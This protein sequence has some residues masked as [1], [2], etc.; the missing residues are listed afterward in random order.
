MLGWFSPSCPLGTREK[1]WV[2]RRMAWLAGRF[3][4]ERL[5]KA[6]ILLPTEEFFPDRYDADEASAQVY[7]DRMCGYMG[8][9]PST[10]ELIVVADDDMPGAAG[11]YQM[12]ER[13]EIYVARSQLT[14]P[15]ELLSTYAHELAH[16][17]LLK[18]GHLTADES[19]HEFVTDILPV[20]LGAG[21]FL[22]NAT[23]KSKAWSEGTMH[24]FSISKQGYLSSITQG[25][26]LALFAFMRG[27][28]RPSWQSHLRADAAGP[29]KSGLRY[30]SKT[31]DTLFHPDTIQSSQQSS[32]S[33]LA[34]RLAHRSPTFRLAALW[35]IAEM[36]DP[37]VDLLPGVERCLKDRDADVRVGALESLSAFGSAATSLVPELAERSFAGTPAERATAIRTLG[38]IKGRPEIAVPAL[39]N[40]LHDEYEEAVAAAAY[41]LAKFGPDAEAAE[42]HLLRA[43]QRE[44]AVSNVP[45]VEALAVALRAVC[46]DLPTLLRMTFAGKDPEG[47]RLVLSVVR[48]QKA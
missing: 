7:F 18:G 3:G 36:S 13:S 26:A 1:T 32:P 35:D 28:I 14:A 20:F 46:T 24:L 16:E 25:Y 38:E 2:E 27:E 33:E 15:M 23:V 43:V 10:V 39:A 44:A 5:R 17:L 4:I 6:R 45:Q 8:V 29:L 9:D 30:L 40:A 42:P 34:E 19:D 21:I 37:P 48:D 31:G 41:A 12:H 47:L 11:L 22:A